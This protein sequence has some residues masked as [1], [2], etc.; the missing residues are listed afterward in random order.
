MR[1]SASAPPSSSGRGVDAPGNP[2][3]FRSVM[4]S[5]AMIVIADDSSARR[6]TFTPKPTTHPR[7]SMQHST[8]PIPV[9]VLG[10][11][12]SVGQRFIALLAAHLWFAVHALGA[13]PR[14]AGKPYKQAVNWKQVQPMPSQ[15]MDMIV[16]KCK[17]DAFKEC[18]FIFSGLDADVAGDIAHTLSYLPAA[19]AIEEA[20]RTAELAV[21]SNAK[22]FWR[23]PHVPLIVSLVNPS[24]LAII[25]SSRLSVLQASKRLHRHQRQLQH[26]R[27]RYP[28]LRA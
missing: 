24:H 12:G 8:A 2:T 22:N 9:G 11:T 1:Q 4:G 19:L 14:S 5:P 6:S 13:S 26:R 10:A 27:I 3:V 18:K 15:V 16:H 7:T 23:E 21:L 25:R 17:A 28:A 20:F